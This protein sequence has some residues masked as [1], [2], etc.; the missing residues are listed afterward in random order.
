MFINATG[1]YVPSTRVPNDYFEKVNGLT[2]DWILQRTGIETRSKVAEGEDVF[3]MGIK[4]VENAMQRL[5]YS[6]R[7]VDLIISAGYTPQDTVGTLA[8]VIQRKFA[9]E[10]AASLMIS[11][12]C[13]SC[14]NALEI[15]EGYFAIHKA[16]KALIIC[17]ENN[18]FYN[19]EHDPKSGHLWGDAAV[20]LF[21]SKE[22]ISDREPEILSITTHGLGHIGRGPGGVY[23][24]LKQKVIE[25]PNGKDVFANAT[26]FMIDAV[27]EVT[28]KRNIELQ[29]LDYIIAHQANM[30]I[31]D[32]VLHQLNFSPEKS[33]TNIKNYGNTGSAS[34]FLVMMEHEEKFKKGD[35]IGI[36]VFGGG[37]S[38]GATLIRY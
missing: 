28:Q 15:V 1:Y 10:N 13:S 32:N 25:M 37:Y 23:L 3:T 27:T 4:A 9:I 33:L 7:D 12:A 8:H 17:S 24:S 20:A 31:I 29:D 14:V 6:I 16:S 34:A 18:S 30:R 22:R 36:T 11:S 38:S 2:S 19:N 21:I 35:L 26:R 5:P